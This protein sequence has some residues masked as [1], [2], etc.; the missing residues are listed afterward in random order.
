MTPVA[1][2]NKK[3]YILRF[4]EVGES[5]LCGMEEGFGNAAENVGLLSHGCV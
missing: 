5:L 4:L 3:K 1:L 2:I